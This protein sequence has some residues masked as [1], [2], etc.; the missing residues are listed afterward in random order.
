MAVEIT[1]HNLDHPTVRRYVVPILITSLSSQ[2]NCAAT[3][4]LVCKKCIMNTNTT[5]N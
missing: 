1:A 5:K 2:L 3:T 4:S